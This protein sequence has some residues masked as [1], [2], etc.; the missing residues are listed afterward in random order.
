MSK[1]SKHSRS[2]RQ[3]PAAPSALPVE[4]ILTPAAPPDATPLWH[5]A[6]SAAALACL[7]LVLYAWT[8]DF[9]MVFDDD[10][11]LRS[12]PL[13]HDASSFTYPLHFTEFVNKPRSIGADPDLA[14][15]F[16]LRP[17]AYASFYINHL[18]DGFN[19]RWYRAL[20]ILIHAANA[21]LV[22]VLLQLLLRRGGLV[23]SSRLFIAITAAAL[24]A[25]H[26][27]A[28]E[29]VTYIIQRF[30]S[31]AAFFCLLALCLHFLAIARPERA[32]LLRTGAVVV[33]IGGMLT[34]ECSIVIPLMAVMLDHL[35]IRATWRQALW[36]A[37]PLLL[38]LP[39]IPVL[40]LL[41]STAQ[42]AGTLDLQTA[43]NIVNTKDSPQTHWEYAIT[44]FTVVVAYLQRLFWPTGLNLDPEWPLY[45]SLFVQPI[46]LSLLGL[47]AMITVFWWLRR[48]YQADLRF[49]AAFSFL[50]WFF[51]T[52]SI[53]SGVVP[54][55]DLMADHRTYLP[56]IGIFVIVACMLDRLRQCGVMHTLVPATTA[57]SITALTWATCERNTVWSTA[58]N[59]WED[60]AAKSPGKHRVWSNLGA[61]YSDRGDNERALVCFRKS[62]DIEPKFQNG[63]FNLS[64]SLLR[65]GKYQESLDVTH[66]LIQQSEH[67]ARNPMVLYTLALGLATT[68]KQD[69]A[70]QV[71]ND[72]VK[73]SPTYSDPHRVLGLIY[74]EKQQPHLAIKH[75]HQAA[76]LKKPDQALLIQI[77][78]VEDQLAKLVTAQ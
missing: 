47:L 75:F 54:L 67:A 1:R 49:G 24:F 42:N 76:S 61:A 45:H 44:Q 11:Y 66:N 6:I 53:S 29:S 41:T 2:R 58:V 27:L 73:L 56:S 12:N 34:K 59:L 28:T 46:I 3:Q 77:K 8:L 9:P 23:R 10:M 69:E 19:P 25:A 50:V 68:G 70:I 30:T 43:L 57:I 21:V 62:T 55:P 20:N 37:L 35:L 71:L 22:Y 38:C 64:N 33:M 32:W 74:K 7:S 65:L 16:V 17:V 15:N 52:I 39:I 78:Q 13:F 4:P 26:P 72:C 18:F 60:T 5:H 51:A 48:R 40:V 14:T 36:R 31:L 63:V